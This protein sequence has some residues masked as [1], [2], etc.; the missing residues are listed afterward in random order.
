MNTKLLGKYSYNI[1]GSLWSVLTKYFGI[2][3]WRATQLISLLGI[4]KSTKVN[5][6]T[7]QELI[8]LNKFATK[9]YIF[10]PKLLQIKNT[11][12]NDHKKNG[13]YKGMRFRQGLPANGQRTHTNA[14]TAK[15]LNRT[16]GNK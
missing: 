15:K 2:N 1:N 11:I 7:S 10:G 5:Q 12:I 4:N 3:F 6:L 8:K 16:W 9:N 14:K 13:S